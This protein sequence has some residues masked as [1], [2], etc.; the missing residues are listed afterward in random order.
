MTD[1]HD[2][3]GLQV[4]PPHRHLDTEHPRVE[5]HCQMFLDHRVQAGELFIIVVRVHHGLSDQLVQRS[6]AQLTHGGSVADGLSTDV[7]ART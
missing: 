4:D 7:S 3:L 6:T 1:R 5:R 2:P